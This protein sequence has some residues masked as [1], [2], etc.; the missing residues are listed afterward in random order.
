VSG[1]QASLI[2]STNS[3]MELPTPDLSRKQT[4]Q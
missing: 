1:W 2:L 3:L 4:A